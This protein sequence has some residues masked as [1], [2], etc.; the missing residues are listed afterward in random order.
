[1]LPVRVEQLIEEAALTGQS[2][3]GKDI[4]ES[5]I[6]EMRACVCMCC[7]DALERRR[8]GSFIAYACTCAESVEEEKCTCR[9]CVG[10]LGS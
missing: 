7:A 1:M 6:A 8:C 9:F 10:Q 5:R 3:S 2:L 4:P